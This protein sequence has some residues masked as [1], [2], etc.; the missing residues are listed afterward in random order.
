M[1]VRPT[2]LA[3]GLVLG[4]LSLFGV[5][6]NVQAGWV[7]AVAALLGGIVVIGVVWPMRAL[8]GVTVE[9]STPT[10]SRAGD[11]IPVELAVSSA[12][13]ATRGPMLVRDEPFGGAAAV[14][15][16][17]TGTTRTYRGIRAGARRGI[18]TGGPCR[19]SSGA[20]FGVMVATRTIDVPSQ[21][22]VHPRTFAI[23]LEPLLG[24]AARPSR[25]QE[26]DVSSVREYRPGD[27]LRL[28]HWRSSAKR[29]SLVVREFE[30]RDR[31]D[32]TVVADPGPDPDAADAVASIACSFALA[33]IRDGRALAL[34]TGERG[35]V[36]T[37]EA[38]S[39]DRVLDWGAALAPRSTPLEQLI[40]VAT[41]RALVCVT[42]A[43]TPAAATRL[44]AVAGTGRDVI[45]VSVDAHAEVPGAMVIDVRSNEELEACF[46]ASV[47]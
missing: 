45:V 7:I 1:S 35:A 2:K 27:P 39:T 15:P 13:N 31:A 28:I 32:I 10:R 6:T 34:V 18:H 19:L 30:N 38:D 36:S 26:G 9:R 16:F 24:S 8:R 43:P 21:T 29:D 12:S 37:I 33:A 17:L 44:A 41:S 5:G 47:V 42:A 46:S 22:I 25:T 23:A 20:P 4:V 3:V 14:V 40:D 11:P